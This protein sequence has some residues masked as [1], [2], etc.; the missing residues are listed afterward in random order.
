[1]RTLEVV[2]ASTVS[3][4]YSLFYVYMYIDTDNIVMSTDIDTVTDAIMQQARRL[5]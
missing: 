1:M 4:N 2:Q 5:C 3:V